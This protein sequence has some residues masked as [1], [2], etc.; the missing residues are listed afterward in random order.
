ML[1]LASPYSH[2]NPAVRDERYHA[3]CTAVAKLLREG[4]AVFSPIIHSHPLVSHGLPTDWSFWERQDLAHLQ[5]CDELVV[6][7]LDGW[8]QSVGVQAEIQHAAELGKPVWYRAPVPSTT[9]TRATA[10]QEG[11]A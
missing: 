1:Y 4:H 7:M 9:P 2:P 3:A 10:G 11:T 8:E 5:R 6:L